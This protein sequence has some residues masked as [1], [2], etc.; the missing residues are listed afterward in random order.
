M[1]QEK[2]VRI[3]VTG[4]ADGFNKEIERS[5]KNLKEAFSNLDLGSILEEADKKFSNIS[6]KISHIKE[7]VASSRSATIGNLSASAQSGNDAYKNMIDRKIQV[8]EEKFGKAAESIDNFAKIIA[9]H[10]SRTTATQN[11]ANSGVSPSNPNVVTNPQQARTK[12]RMT[13]LFSNTNGSGSSGNLNNL[14]NTIGG[15]GNNLSIGGLAG[16][17]TGVLA[18]GAIGYAITRLVG[19]IVEPG[20]QLA[21]AEAKAS[22]IYDREKTGL[23]RMYNESY[24][25]MDEVELAGYATEVARNRKSAGEGFGEEVKR[26]GALQVAYGL[27]RSE[28][29]QLDKMYRYNGGKDATNIIGDILVKSEK[30]GLLGVSRDDFTRLPEKIGSVVG[31]LGMQ[32]SSGENVDP[33][34][35]V[36][37]TLAGE[38]IG[39][40]FGDDRLQDVMSRMNSSIQSPNNGG[41]KA[42]IFEMLKRSNP[43]ASYTD[44]LGMQENGANSANLKAILPE[45]SK[46]PKGEMRR[47]VLYQLTKN[48]Q[49]AIRLDSSNNLDEML[50]ATDAGASSKS[51][52][53]D[54]Y[55]KTKERS[56]EVQLNW[57]KG[58][59][60]VK[61]AF[62]EA[63]LELLNVFQLGREGEGYGA[64]DYLK[65]GL[66]GLM[67]S[68][69]PQLQ[70]YF[71]QTHK[72]A[73][74]K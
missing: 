64:K 49:D 60:M 65:L 56:R 29:G 26:R 68:M 1:D 52:V 19:A 46:M 32:R 55:S 10:V 44:I 28:I 63:G 20:L 5:R 47:M 6:D 27:D 45:I 9:Q 37:M 69:S 33:N 71:N 59:V 17:I 43:D 12:N 74:K 35:A 14:I 21:R 18:G 25:G 8:N 31:I 24:T 61:D 70:M 2:I 13:R 39:G 30:Q 16:G 42:Y 67:P 4:D 72:P 15:G 54:I 22:A 36:N 48:W 58:K 73:I 57:D 7:N 23:T 3:S 34:F 41:M 51:D 11:P 66:M 50:N 62:Y 40:R 53:E 38:R